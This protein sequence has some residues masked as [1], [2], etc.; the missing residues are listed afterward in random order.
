[1]FI[2]LLL[3]FLLHYPP[4]C[5]LFSL[6]LPLL[7]G[8][9][10]YSTK[11]FLSAPLARSTIK[12]NH[13]LTCDVMMCAIGFSHARKLFTR[14]SRLALARPFS[15]QFC[16]SLFCSRSTKRSFTNNC[17]VLQMMMFLLHSIVLICSMNYILY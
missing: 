15:A 5:L 7:D 12:L 6:L 17:I 8:W 16:S 11:S 1:M 3:L 13:P 4:H 9:W 10:I 2:M 14:I